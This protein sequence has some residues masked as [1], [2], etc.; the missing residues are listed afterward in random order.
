MCPAETFQKVTSASVAKKNILRDL[1]HSLI[2]R[3]LREKIDPEKDPDNE[4]RVQLNEFDKN[5]PK[6][7]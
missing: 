4:L 1:D 6:N 3:P 2:Y 5:C 7:L